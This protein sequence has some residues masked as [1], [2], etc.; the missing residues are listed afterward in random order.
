[1][2]HGITDTRRKLYGREKKKQ[3]GRHIMYCIYLNVGTNSATERPDALY[4]G[5]IPSIV[6]IDTPQR[7]RYAKVFANRE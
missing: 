5:S 2:D 7:P 3:Y 1:M 4:P 6:Q